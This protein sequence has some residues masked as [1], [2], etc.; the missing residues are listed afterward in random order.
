MFVEQL[1][2]GYN[3]QA[4]EAGEPETCSIKRLWDC[5]DN[6]GSGTLE[7]EEF[8][9]QTIRINP[10]VHRDEAHDVFGLIDLDGSDIITREEFNVIMSGMTFSGQQLDGATLAGKLIR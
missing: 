7:R 1:I 2:I 9:N 5:L 3:R 10:I 6:D 8:V 4:K